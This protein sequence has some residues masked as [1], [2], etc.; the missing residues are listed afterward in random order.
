LKTRRVPASPV[1]AVL[2]ACLDGLDNRS[3]N[4]AD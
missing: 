4:A 1:H 2:G 3:P